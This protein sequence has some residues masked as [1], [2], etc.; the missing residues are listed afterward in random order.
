MLFSSSQEV[1]I[2]MVLILSGFNS[3]GRSAFDSF[4]LQD[5]V[6]PFGQNEELVSLVKLTITDLTD[7]PEFMSER[8]DQG[9]S[10]C[11]WK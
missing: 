10:S 6:R 4:V 8:V 2:L 5:F 1:L 3:H 11:A 7:R 9:S